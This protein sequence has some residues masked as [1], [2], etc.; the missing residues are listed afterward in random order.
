MRE[1]LLT[2]SVLILAVALLRRLLRGRIDPR[3]QYA[4]W[5][6]VALRLLIPGSLFPAPVSV[7]G[8]AEAAQSAIAEAL[9]P[10]ET[11]GAAP[12]PAAPEALP[13]Q[14]DPA[15]SADVPEIVPQEAPSPAGTARDWPRTVWFAGMAVTA[16]A[17]F[18]SNA[19][20]YVR[21][22]RGR[23]RL[24]AEE[25][26]IPC[27]TAV[28]AAEEPASPCLFGLLRPSIYLNEAA[29]SPERLAHILIHEQTHLRHLDHLW[30]L[31]RGLCLTV[32]WF[33][34]LVWWAAALSRRD[35]EIACDA[36]AIRRLGED[37]RLDYGRTLVAMVAPRT[38]PADLLRTATTMTGGKRTMTERVR[39]IAQKPR[40]RWLALA[41]LALAVAA[42]ALVTFGGAGKGASTDS[43]LPSGTQGTDYVYTH[44]SGLF[45]LALPE[46]WAEDVTA[47]ETED[48]VNFFEAN[49][50]AEAEYGWLMAVHPQ[51]AAWVEEHA[52]GNF[53][54][55]DSFTRHNVSYQYILEYRLDEDFAHEPAA[56]PYREQ[57]QSLLGQRQAVAGGFRLLAASDGA[58][59]GAAALDNDKALALYG[60][61]R[62]AWDWFELGT[63]PTAGSTEGG[64]SRVDGF[65]SLE[66]LRSYLRT[67][68]SQDLTERLLTGYQRFQEKDGHLYVEEAG[69]GASIYA[70][71][72]TVTAFLMNNEEAARY[73]YDCHI[74]ARTEVLDEDL[75]TALYQKRHDWF[76]AWDGK[77]YVFTSFGPWDDVDPA[78]GRNARAILVHI[79]NGD[80]TVEWLPLME[81]MDWA[82]LR[83]AAVGDEFA[84]SRLCMAVS[85][86]M[87]RCAAEQEEALLEDSYRYILSATEG[88]DGAYAE[89][90]SS[91][92]WELYE[93]NPL[94]FAGVVL[95]DL[96]P[97]QRSEV[98]GFLGSELAYREGRD[99]SLPAQEV[100]DRLEQ[101]LISKP[102]LRS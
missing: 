90:F 69:R 45:S 101:I 36:G 19:A 48:G 33:D 6:L 43:Y 67:L 28:Y 27:P 86:A 89:G 30:A 102:P 65:D 57:F 25:L 97:E 73:G 13:P 35:C 77:H 42:V 60:K 11:S 82:A 51:P 46:N 85:E 79:Q 71:E 53:I 12:V 16:A 87:S 93:Q 54:P 76:V 37:R 32:Y 38:S 58:S 7:M 92:V 41:A 50:Y 84:A 17:L 95:E 29:L 70:G 52:E 61:A 100:L 15:V 83:A 64:Y 31:L 40:N 74:F 47:V 22:R 24:T 1:I 80:P 14:T 59:D 66:A 88:L 3:I 23:R 39:L 55:L 18:L 81:N 78:V 72:E 56:G 8:A 26:P 91:T 99:E 63:I 96:T 9:P 68:F 94:R 21:L 2:S 49:T 62:E 98:V 34:P 4:L 75:T 20:F 5:L 10:R 44:S